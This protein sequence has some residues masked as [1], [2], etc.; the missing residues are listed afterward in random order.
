MEVAMNISNKYYIDYK[1]TILD[2][3]ANKKVSHFKLWMSVYYY[4]NGAGRN[5]DK[6]F[7]SEFEWCRVK[8]MV[9]QK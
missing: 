3:L 1:Q 6:S 2:A 8:K 5:K 9:K 4:K 7:L